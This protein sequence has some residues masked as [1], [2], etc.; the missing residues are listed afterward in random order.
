M[1]RRDRARRLARC[2][3]RRAVVW[4]RHHGE[5][6][7]SGSSTSDRTRSACSST[8]AGSRC[9]PARD[10][11]ARRRRRAARLD[12]A[13]RSSP[14]RGSARR[15][16]RG[17]C[18]RRTARRARGA[19]HEPRPPGGERRR[20][21]RRCSASRPTAPARHPQR[22]GGRAPRVSSARSRSPLRSGAGGSRSSTSAAA[23]RRSS[24]A[25]GATG[26]S[27][28]RSIDLGSLRLTSGCSAAT[29]RASCA[30]GRARG[31]ERYLDGFDPPGRPR[32]RSRRQRARAEADRRATLGSEE[33]EEA[34][35]LLAETPA[36]EV[37]RGSGSTRIASAR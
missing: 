35:A 12:P 24:S 28:L 1:R 10:A 3:L 37:V 5:C 22:G 6:R 31:G 7:W 11:P 23:R 30:R 9:S 21:A 33:L 26:R 25:H 2:A 4:G 14:S 19:D 36:A 29:R 17:R 20:A 15:F 18:A 34:L 13:T 16:V 32:P 27:W 8:A